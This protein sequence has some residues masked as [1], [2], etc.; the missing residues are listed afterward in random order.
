MTTDTSGPSPGTSLHH[1]VVHPAYPVLH[2]STPASSGPAGMLVLV[3]LGSQGGVD[4][5]RLL[6][7]VVVFTDTAASGIVEGVELFPLCG[8]QA[9]KVT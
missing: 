5:W 2:T 6:V 8:V 4:D 3:I 1:P 9:V 7:V